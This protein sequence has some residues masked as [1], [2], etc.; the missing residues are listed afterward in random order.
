MSDASVV[1]TNTTSRFGQDDQLTEWRRYTGCL[2]CN[3][4]TSFFVVRAISIMIEAELNSD[5]CGHPSVLLK[6]PRLI[7]AAYIPAFRLYNDGRFQILGISSAHRVHGPLA[8]VYSPL[9]RSSCLPVA[10]N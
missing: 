5:A 2:A 8:F 3:Y 10:T 6:A 4:Y 7:Q 1:L 9:V